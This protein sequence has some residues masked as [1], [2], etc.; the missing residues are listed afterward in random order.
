MS[1]NMSDYYVWFKN[2]NTVVVYSIDYGYLLIDFIS[3][4]VVWVNGVEGV[5]GVYTS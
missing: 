5:T 3:K 4:N 2:T 1:D